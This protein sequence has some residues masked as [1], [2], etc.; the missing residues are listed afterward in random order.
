M[1]ES[2]LHFLMFFGSLFA[3]IISIGQMLRRGKERIDYIFAASFFG[4]GIWLFQ[5]SLYSTGVFDHWSGTYYL[6]TFLIPFNFIVPALMVLRYRWILTS[7]FHIRSLHLLMFLPSLVSIIVILVP[8]FSAEISVPHKDYPGLPLLTEKFAD[9]SLYSKILFSLYFLPNLYLIVF[10]VPVLVKMSSVWTKLSYSGKQGA[11]RV[12]YIFAS[13]IVFSNVVCVA[14]NL[15]SFDLIKAS[16]IMANIATVMVFIVTQRSPDYLR[17]LQSETRRAY[18]EKTRLKGLDVKSI[19]SRLYEIMEDE[20]AFAYEEITLNDL[21]VELGISTHQLS[22][23][24]NERIKKN[25][26]TFINEFRVAE[27]KKLLLEERD[28]S[29]LSIGA[30]VGFNSNTTFCTVFLKMTGV[31]PGQY[32]KNLS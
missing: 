2:I 24:L 10:M 16:I 1:T 27:A 20:K 28:R 9:L 18:Y 23:I 26:K 22:E 31:S 25:F 12:G 30:A 15:I 8:F 7:S 17:L 13:T 29:V 32:R 3:V 11:A 4:M 5:I 6:V 19:I 14:G 21:S